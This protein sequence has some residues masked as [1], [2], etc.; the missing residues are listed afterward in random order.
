MEN[1]QQES[2]FFP[3]YLQTILV[4]SLRSFDIYITVKGRMV[5]Y[6]AKGDRFNAEVKDNLLRNK[7][8]TLYLPKSDLDAYNRYLEENL[9]VIL[10]NPALSTEAKAEVAHTSIS[11][12][13]RVFFDNPRSQTIARYKSTVNATMDF[14]MKDA[15]AIPNLIR[16]TSHDFTTYIHS[17]NVGIFAIGL[18]KALLATDSSHDMRELSL[19]FFLHDIGKCSTPLNVLNKPGPLD[20]EEWKVMRRHP[21]DGYRLLEQMNSLTKESRVIVMEHHERHDGTGYPRRLKGDQ[22]HIYSKI[23]CIADVFDALTSVRPYKE[24]KTP[25]QAL[26]IMKDQMRSDFDPVFFERFV[27]LFSEGKYSKS[28]QKPAPKK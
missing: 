10:K 19:G 4:D 23:C 21:F 27:L 14:I 13:A 1:Q 20:E 8:D 16:L 28:Y 26:Q 11:N 12:T 15:H 2:Q 22:I 3:V 24:S 6:H 17:V 25:F 9:E 5:L 18:A 7:I